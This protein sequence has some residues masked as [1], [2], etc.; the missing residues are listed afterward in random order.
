MP[1]LKHIYHVLT[2]VDTGD[3]VDHANPTRQWSNQD[4]VTGTW[5]GNQRNTKM[6][7]SEYLRKPVKSQQIDLRYVLRRSKTSK[8]N[9]YLLIVMPFEKSDTITQTQCCREHYMN[10]WH[11]TRSVND[12]I[13]NTYITMTMFF[14]CDLHKALTQYQYLHTYCYTH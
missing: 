11:A 13:Y 9:L 2:V 5:D 10:Y 8:P 14:P 7:T 3:V 1:C 4:E 6:V 12:C